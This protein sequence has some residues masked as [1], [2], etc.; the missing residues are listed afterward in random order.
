ML[1]IYRIFFLALKKVKMVEVTLQIPTTQKK[2][3][4]GKIF[5]SPQLGRDI[6]RKPLNVNRKILLGTSSLCIFSSILNFKSS[7]QGID[8][9]TKGSF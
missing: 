4:P 3:L 8:L 1:N 5:Y 7:N 9:Q 2:L 6:L